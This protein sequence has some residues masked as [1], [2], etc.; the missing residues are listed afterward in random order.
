MILLKAI[1]GFDGAR[2]F[3]SP[4]SPQTWAEGLQAVPAG[5]PACFC[6][7]NSRS[8]REKNLRHKSVFP[9]SMQSNTGLILVPG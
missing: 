7:Q 9:A 6:T 8:E 2:G 3:S 1:Y 4:E 5:P